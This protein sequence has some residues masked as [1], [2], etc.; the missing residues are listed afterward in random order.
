[1]SSRVA[2]QFDDLEQQLEAS[3]LGM[4]VFLGTE[5]LFFGGLFAGYTAYRYKFA[6]AFAE[7]SQHL[8]VVLGTF[9]TGVLLLSSLTMALSVNSVQTGKRKAML[10]F[11]AATMVLGTVFLGIKF[12][13][14]RHKFVEHLVPGARFSL[15]HLHESGAA[16]A[17]GRVGT[18]AEFGPDHVAIERDGKLHVFSIAEDLQ[19]TLDGRPARF[20]DLAVGQAA[21]VVP[22]EEGDG[23]VANSIRANSPRVELFFSF[24]FA[25]TGFHALHMIIGVV[26]VGIVALMARQ[27]R[28]SPEYYTPVEMTGLYWHFVDIVW[29]FLFPLLYLIDLTR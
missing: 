13:E 7:G 27:G 19:V 21:R 22:A 25:M 28:F 23:A 24:Y 2:H 17:T 20:G 6:A 14:Y 10:R 16:E 15:V 12:V 3:T 18:I 26:A 9:N 8:D 1:M 11:L 4:W 29:V 5:V